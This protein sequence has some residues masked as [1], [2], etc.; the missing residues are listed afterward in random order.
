MV[1]AGYHPPL[2]A[3]DLDTRI[4]LGCEQSGRV[5][6]R[7][8]RIGLPLDFPTVLGSPGAEFMTAV[9]VELS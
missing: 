6:Y 9:A 8:A 4:A 1:V 2:P 5:A 7:L 3:D